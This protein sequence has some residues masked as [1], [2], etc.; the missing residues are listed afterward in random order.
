MFKKSRT[1]KYLIPV[2]NHLEDVETEHKELKVIYI[3]S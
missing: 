3:N 1:V 2:K